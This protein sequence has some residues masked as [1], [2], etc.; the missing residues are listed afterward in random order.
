MV[1]TSNRKNV[2]FIIRKVI[3][4][5]V[6]FDQVQP[7][8]IE[9]QLLLWISSAGLHLGGGRGGEC[10]PAPPGLHTPTDLKYYCKSHI[11]ESTDPQNVPDAILEALDT[12]LESISSDPL[13]FYIKIIM[14]TQFAPPSPSPVNFL[15]TALLCDIILHTEYIVA[16]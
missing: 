3:S 8:G 15:N 9:E 10:A 11:S 5:G 7:C 6:H 1:T 16:N 2:S 14:S 4:I 12:K 13:A